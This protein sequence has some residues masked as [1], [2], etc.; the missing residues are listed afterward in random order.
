MINI[1]AIY[2][3]V[4]QTLLDNPLLRT[5]IGYEIE[6]LKDNLMKETDHILH[7]IL[8][9]LADIYPQAVARGGTPWM[10]DVIKDINNVDDDASMMNALPPPHPFRSEKK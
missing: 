9:N 3:E 1:H 6:T 5:R 4:I 8:I 2:R 7:N 10:R